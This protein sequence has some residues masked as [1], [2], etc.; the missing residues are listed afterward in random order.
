MIIYCYRYIVI[1]ERTIIP[2][3]IWSLMVNNP[4][5]KHV[6]EAIHDNECLEWVFLLRQIVRTT[7]YSLG[8]RRSN[9]LNRFVR[10]K[11]FCITFL[12]LGTFLVRLLSSKYAI[13][14]LNRIWLKLK[15]D[16]LRKVSG[17]PP[18]WKVNFYYLFFYY[19]DAHT[20]AL[21]KENKKF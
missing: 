17:L 13:S 5:Y 2:W 7:N 1:C 19:F 14:S 4:I 18:K 15:F 11:I 10:A 8:L 9:L 16:F 20:Y 3:L 12:H 6:H 21:Q